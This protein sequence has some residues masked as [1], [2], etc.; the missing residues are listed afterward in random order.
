[1]SAQPDDDPSLSQLVMRTARALRRVNRDELEPFGLTPSQAR[2]LGVI[3][4]YGDSPPRLG[5]IAAR[6]DIAPR[7][8]TEVVDDLQAL[9]LV[10]RVPDPTDRRAVTISLTGEGRAVRKRIERARARRGD[11]FF[12]HLT[13]EQRAGLQDLLQQALAPH[14]HTRSKP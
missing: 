14:A 2:A 4:R 9:G 3:S 13:P 1:M 11:E 6:L 10:Q 5:D 12:G 7:S 8:A